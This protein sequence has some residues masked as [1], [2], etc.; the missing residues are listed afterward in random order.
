MENLRGKI[1]KMLREFAEVNELF[2]TNHY[3]RRVMDRIKEVKTYPIVMSTPDQG[4]LRF[5]EVG[6]YELTE[7]EKLMILDNLSVAESVDMPT[8]GEYGIKIYDFE[9]SHN[10]LD[11]DSFDIDKKL[12]IMKSIHQGNSSL[13][14]QDL[15]TKS[16][17]DILFMIIED[18]SIKT[19]LYARS[20]NLE[21][22]YNHLEN[23]Y[24]MD[25]IWLLKD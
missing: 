19:I 7:P 18:Q 9:L 21:D 3:A 2:T 14:I 13:Y 4:K 15:I 17:G 5:D 22:K 8:D 12:H 24:S 10:D 16:T 25:E 11:M 6:T 23:I 20:Y 1:K